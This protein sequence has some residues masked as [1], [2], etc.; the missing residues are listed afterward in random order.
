MEAVQR[1]YAEQVQNVSGEWQENSL[2]FRFATYGMKISGAM[3]VGE[4]Q[5]DVSGPLPLL[6]AMFR[7]KIEQQIRDEL[8]KLLS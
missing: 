3:D 7:G 6:A 5:V 1:D 4:T 8:S 2:H